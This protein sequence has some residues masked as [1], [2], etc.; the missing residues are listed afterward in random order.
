MKELDW[1]SKDFFP[2]YLAPMAGVTDFIFRKMCKQLGADVMVTEFVSAEGIIHEDKRTRKYTEFDN[3]QR[4]LGVQ[5]FGANP[6]NMAKAAEK[7]INWKEPEFIDINYG[8]P[9]KKV[10]SKNGGSSL[11]KQC[12]LLAKV[13]E[14]IVKKVGDKVPVTA[15]IRIGWDEKSINAPDICKI[16]ENVGISAIAIHGRT[17]AQGYTGKANWDVINDCAK[18]VK[19]PVIG[20][21]DISDIEQIKNIQKNSNVSGIMIGRAAL[22]N[23]WLFTQ[24]K[25]YKEKQDYNLEISLEQRWDFMINHCRETILSNKFS[26]ELSAMRAMRSRLMSYTKGIVGGKDIRT[27]FSKITS[28]SQLLDISKYHLDNYACLESNC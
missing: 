1:L 5:L 14:T 6:E 16:L 4:P 10:V 26:D 27:M 20:N 7:I 28:L 11:L 15:K 21:G 12:D 9:V 22:N 17:R 3:S 13:S 2:I 8:C 24:I 25:R 18:I 19:I 23:P